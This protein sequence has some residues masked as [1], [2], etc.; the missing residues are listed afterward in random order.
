[1]EGLKC[2]VFGSFYQLSASDLLKI[3]EQLH[4]PVDQAQ[5]KLQIIR[6]IKTFL[7]NKEGEQDDHGLELYTNVILSI[8]DLNQPSRL[9]SETE[10]SIPTQSTMAA[11]RNSVGIRPV[12]AMNDTSSWRK[13][14]KI[15]G[16]IGLVGQKDKLTYSNLSRQIQQG[17]IKGYP[18]T[19]IVEAVIK[20]ITPGL[21]FLS[22]LERH[23]TP[24]YSC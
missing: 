12:S 15:T 10:T 22:E 11:A 8:N 19:E 3:S 4:V 16:Q 21:S 24:G 17:R 7:G 1:M 6:K 5:S 20:S 9:V 23:V 18:N 14:F 13:E 2:Q